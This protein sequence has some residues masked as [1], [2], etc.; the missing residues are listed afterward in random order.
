M[1]AADPRSRIHLELNPLGKDIHGPGP[2]GAQALSSPAVSQARP[3]GAGCRQ[4]LTPANQMSR[5]EAADREK[6]G[7][8]TGSD[9]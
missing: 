5:G 6:K 2:Q 4:N 8:I 7:G 9:E 1:A 3:Q